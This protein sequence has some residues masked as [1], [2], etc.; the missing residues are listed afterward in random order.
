MRARSPRRWWA[1]RSPADARSPPPHILPVPFVPLPLDP[2]R[3]V[4]L[5]LSVVP[6]ADWGAL[7]T[8][9][10]FEL[11]EEGSGRGDDLHTVGI[12][13]AGDDDEAMS[14]AL[15]KRRHSLTEWIVVGRDPSPRRAVAALQAGA[16]DYF[17][18]PADMDL[19]RVWLSDWLR[20]LPESELERA[21]ILALEREAS[22]R[23]VVYEPG[24]ARRY[25]P[26]RLRRVVPPSRGEG[27]DGAVDGA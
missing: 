13:I 25:T 18:L 17:V 7:A 14:R 2:P 16:Q 5:P 26:P 27:E 1:R 4:L 23:A 22:S 10:G 9:L 8:E 20:Q 11:D 3:L 21:M 19:M 15:S 24:A 6:F 12:L